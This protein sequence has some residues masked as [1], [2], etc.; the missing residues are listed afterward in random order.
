MTSFKS[1]LQSA[2]QSVLLEQRP[3][4]EA[5]RLFERGQQQPQAP[6]SNHDKQVSLRSDIAIFSYYP[7]KIEDQRNSVLMDSKLFLVNEEGE[8]AAVKFPNLFEEMEMLRWAGVGLER[9]E[10]YRL[11]LSIKKLAEK[12]PGDVFALRFWGR[13]STLS[14]PYFVVEGSNTE[15]DSEDLRSQEGKDG[16]NR[17]AYWVSQTLEPESWSQLPQV[18]CAQI[19]IATKFTR[20]LTGNLNAPV[21]SYPPFPGKEKDL[22]RAQIARISS[23]TSISPTGYFKIE[24][25]EV[26]YPVVVP[27]YEE[28]MRETQLLHPNQMRCVQAWRHHEREL[29]SLGRITVLPEEVGEDGEP[30]VLEENLVPVAAALAIPE[31]SL[32]AFQTAPISSNFEGNAV[33]VAK[34]IEW[35]GAVVAAGLKKFVC[36]YN[37]NGVR[38]T[39]A[40]SMPLKPNTVCIELS[41]TQLLESNDPTIDPIPPRVSDTEDDLKNVSDDE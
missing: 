21:P 39:S 14:K 2:L 41:S 22:L 17:Y 24:D 29:N 26:D 27:I 38:Y 5:L 12:L 6:L 3:P 35:P 30:I 28:E 34:S 13:V 8:A 40:Q 18:T 36:A 37:G 11:Y 33:V 1:G 10:T 20:F 4:N 15:D 7:L 9:S 32:W 25:P 23:S 16:A 19:V 31:K